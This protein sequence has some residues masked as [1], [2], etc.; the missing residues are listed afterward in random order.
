[1]EQAYQH[2]KSLHF[3]DQEIAAKI[4][5][6]ADPGEAKRLS[7]ELKN[8][9]QDQWDCNRDEMML[10]L[11]RAK[12]SHNSV[13][14]DELVASGKKKIGESGKLPYFAVGLSITSNDILEQNLWTG[15]SKLRSILM[16]VRDELKFKP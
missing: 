1:M 8:F 4:M 11:I 3:K 15:Q 13:I 12:F 6:T 16:T 10:Q 14:A 5:R 2:L 9:V 7:S